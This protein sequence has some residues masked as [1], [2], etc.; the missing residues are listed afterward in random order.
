MAAE[1]KTVI[2]LDLT[3]EELAVV[4]ACL[5]I[6]VSCFMNS[7]DGVVTGA[8]LLDHDRDVLEQPMRSVSKRVDMLMKEHVVNGPL[9]RSG[10]LPS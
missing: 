2:R 3:E 7:L 10:N 6:G 5:A 1:E 9:A 8:L 4:G